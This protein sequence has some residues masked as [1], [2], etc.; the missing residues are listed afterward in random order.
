MTHAGPTTQCTECIHVE[1]TIVHFYHDLH[2]CH[3]ASSERQK[4]QYCRSPP[5][6][7][8]NNHGKAFVLCNALIRILCTSPLIDCSQI[9]AITNMSIAASCSK[10]VL[11]QN[12]TL[13]S[14]VYRSRASVSTATLKKP[15]PVIQ[16]TKA[17]LPLES[18]QIQLDGTKLHYPSPPPPNVSGGKAPPRQMQKWLRRLG[19]SMLGGA[20]PEDKIS[21]SPVYILTCYD[22]C[23][24]AVEA[25]YDF[26]HKGMLLLYR[27]CK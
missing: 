10:S 26:F 9:G 14:T 18:S 19:T 21:T 15:T 16:S 2:P 3:F 20:K 6:P 12:A 17:R 1:V 7:K 11:H 4:I 25:N 23:A 27:I 22:A 24:K 13:I 5:R 8:K